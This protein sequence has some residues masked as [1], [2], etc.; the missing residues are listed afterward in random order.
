MDENDYVEADY[1]RHSL[2]HFSC[3]GSSHISMKFIIIWVDPFDLEI[4]I[5]TFY[6]QLEPAIFSVR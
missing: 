3:Y 6:F 1:V 2:I 5:N 4:K